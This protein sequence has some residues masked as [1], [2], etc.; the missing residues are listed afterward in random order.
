[1][2]VV[3]IMQLHLRWCFKI[4]KR[5]LQGI[6]TKNRIIKC[7]RKLFRERGYH[8]VT[9]DDI[10]KDANSSK[11]GFYTH[12]KTK[13]ELLFNMAPLV[14]DAYTAF[15]KMDIKAETVIEKIAL[16]IKYVFNTIA[17][18]IGLEFI[19]AIYAS[20]IKDLTTQR[21]LISSERT[22]YQVFGTLIEE[23]KAKNEIKTELSPEHTIRLFTSCIRGAIYDWCLN[24]GEF[25][26]ADY[27]MEIVNMLL[28]QIKSV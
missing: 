8:A 12:F 21:F 1:M 23:G 3:S 24:K 7:A 11:G 19:S 14:D 17:E 20:Q 4:K 10:I 22:Y 9:V 28:H 27:G 26:L 18:E 15:L 6:E 5:E 25:N 16:F 13:E 2:T